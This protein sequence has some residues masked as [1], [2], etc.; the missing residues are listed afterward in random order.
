MLSPYE[1]S[2]FFNEA[3]FLSQFDGSDFIFIN[4]S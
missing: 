3:F 2:F 1:N 4:K